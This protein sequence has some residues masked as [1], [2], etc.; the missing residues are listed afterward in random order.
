[1]GAAQVL[2]QTARDMVRNNPYAERAVSAIAGDL[3]GTGITFEVRRK[4]VPDPELTA[5]AKAHL[6]TTKCDAEG[7]HNIYGL[8]LLAARTM[9][10]SGA[11][12]ARYRPRF[13]RD[14]LPYR[15]R[16]RCWSRIT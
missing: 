7:R 16:S 12:L 5:L 2:A 15:F 4:G 8:Q 11:V 14:G 9:V 13:A 3:V 10:E 6:E 1:M